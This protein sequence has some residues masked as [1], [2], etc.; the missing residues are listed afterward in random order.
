MRAACL[1]DA[2]E[3]AGRERDGELTCGVERG[4]TACRR[5][6]GRAAMAVER[7]VERLEHH[8]LRRAHRPQRRQLVAEQRTRVGV[9][10][11]PRLLDDEPAHGGEVV[12]RRREPVLGQ[13]FGGDGIARL[14]ALAQRE[15]GL[16]TAG[17]GA[18]TRD[19]EN[20]VGCEIWRLDARRRLG[21]RAVA[22]P[23]AAQLGQRDEDLGGVCDPRAV[24]AVAHR[25]REREEL[26]K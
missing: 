7:G 8:A 6:V 10:Q 2:D 1:A 4:Q 18:R 14:G 11:Q 22:A 5:L 16:V 23:V 13:P 17:R 25:R 20:L 24:G 3:D 15:Q 12:E 26:R 21:E 19:R 9:R